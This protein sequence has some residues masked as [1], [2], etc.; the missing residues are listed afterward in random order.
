MTAA[1]FA[2]FS[3]SAVPAKLP[4]QALHEMRTLCRGMFDPVVE[5]AS[6]S[7]PPSWRLC[8]ARPLESSTRKRPAALVAA[9]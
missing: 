9:D 7:T 5:A 3:G 8:R 6:R 4:V 1:G 2:A